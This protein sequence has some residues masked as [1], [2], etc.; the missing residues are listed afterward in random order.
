MLSILYL[1]TES[2]I[3]DLVKSFTETYGTKENSL[4]NRS[5]YIRPIVPLLVKIDKRRDE[6][7][8]IQSRLIA[9]P[10]LEE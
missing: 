4:K 3:N 7:L 9:N 2:A 5:K 1:I 6:K 10:P 8:F